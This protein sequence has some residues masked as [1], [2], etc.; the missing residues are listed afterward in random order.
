MKKILLYGDSNTYGY[1]PRGF[2]GMRYPEHVRWTSRVRNYF[3]GKCKIIEEGQNGRCLPKL[4]GEEVYLTRIIEPLSEDDVLLI[5]LGTN[6]VL[7]T[8]HPDADMPIRKMEVLIN[9]IINR[10]Q[11]PHI[12]VIGP[13]PISNIS[14]DMQIY[15]DE[16]KRMNAG[17]EIICR[18]EGIQYFD[19]AGWNIEL[20]YDGVHFS[21][22]GC[23]QFAE[24]IID[25]VLKEM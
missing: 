2:L 11:H 13:V 3:E 9:W 25:V 8:N 5:M 12:V 4:P 16:S 6:D 24:H 23:F 18:N 14:G 21:E 22:K 1:D 7:L 17:F 19:A 10:N 15:H 20:A